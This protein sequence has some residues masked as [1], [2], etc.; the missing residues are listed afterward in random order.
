MPGAYEQHEKAFRDVSAYVILDTNGCIERVA[1]IT[2]KHPRDGAGR[3][4]AYVHWFGQ[5]MVRG[6]ASGGGYDKKS[7]AVGAAIRKTPADGSERHDEFRRA[8]AKDDGRYWD[9][10]LRDAGFIVLQAV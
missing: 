3:L 8:L 9:N 7:A 4:Y 1:T 6:F 2:F 5:A 10:R